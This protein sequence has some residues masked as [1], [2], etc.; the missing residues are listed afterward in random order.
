MNILRWL[1]EGEVGASSKAIALSAL[2]EMPRRPAWPSDGQD[3]RRCMKLLEVCPDA[4]AGLDELERCGGPVWAALV[5]R[6][7]EI[8]EACL[9]DEF[10]FAAG[11]HSPRAYRCYDL[12][13]SIINAANK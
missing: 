4:K 12:M 6:W 11:G 5:K 7:D 9:H 8:G 10:L 13:K 3:L 2:G 1:S